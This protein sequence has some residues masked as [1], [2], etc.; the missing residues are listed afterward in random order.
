[1]YVYDILLDKTK[2]WESYEESK[3]IATKKSA[4]KSVVVRALATSLNLIQHKK[5]TAHGIDPNHIKIIKAFY[6]KEDISRFMPG[7]Q[8]VITIWDENGKKHEEQKSILTMI[9]EAYS[10]FTEAH[11]DV[12]IGKSKFAEM[13][14]DVYIMKTLSSYLKICTVFFLM[15]FHYMVR[16]SLNHV[17]V[18]QTTR[19]AWAQIV[20]YVKTNSN[21]FLLMKSTMKTFEE[22]QHG[23]NGRKM[24]MIEQKK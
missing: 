10:L 12:V 4:Q 23:I 6:R 2:P 11:P 7:K 18:K 1:M 14:V 9:A 24:K 17:S 3:E 21:Q 5:L 15:Y 8:D 19:L 22:V 13:F 16:I 20:P